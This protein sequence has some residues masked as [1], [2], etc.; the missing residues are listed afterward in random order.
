MFE[1]KDEVFGGIVREVCDKIG[2]VPAAVARGGNQNRKAI[3][4]RRAIATKLYDIGFSTGDIAALMK[5][6]RTAVTYLRQESE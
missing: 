6:S 3:E 5:I 2:V 1:T 4:A